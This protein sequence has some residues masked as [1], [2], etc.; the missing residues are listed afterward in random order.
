M[1]AVVSEPAARKPVV[2]YVSLRGS[3]GWFLVI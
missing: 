1:A 2:E 3:S